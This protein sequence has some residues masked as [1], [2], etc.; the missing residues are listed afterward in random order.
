M[1][2]YKY[3]FKTI[4]CLRELLYVLHANC[5]ICK[6]IFNKFMRCSEMNG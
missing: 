6:Y 2:V 5:I 1:Y 3:V 4:K